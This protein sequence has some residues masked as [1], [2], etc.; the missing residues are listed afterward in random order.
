M[1]VFFLTT[2]L[3]WPPHQGGRVRTLSQLRLLS[4][5]PEV[6]SICIFSLTEVA[7]AESDCA[8][9]A[10]AIAAGNPKPPAIQVLPP[11]FHPIHIKRDPKMLLKVL[12]R[13]LRHGEPYLLGKWHSREV[14]AALES[15]LSSATYDV[16]YIDHL[17]M[18][19]YLP[20]VRAQC[21]RARFVLEEH[22]V[23]SD[24]FAQLT[25]RL[26]LPL[27]PV[28]FLEHRTAAR[29]EAERLLAKRARGPNPWR[30]P[31]ATHLIAPGVAVIQ[32]P[33]GRAL[34][35]ALSGG[36]YPPRGPHNSLF[37]VSFPWMLLY[38]VFGVMSVFID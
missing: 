30:A 24:M 4:A 6:E 25:T 16:I 5:Q 31:W 8:A 32:Y 21:P 38:A 14:A 26:P 22:N 11:V 34:L 15:A 10:S 9:L 29:A 3:P 20:L 23:E 1:R 19:A 17:G 35:L 28:S 27:K 18:G 12:G 13:R 7:V 2:E 36:H 33:L 37:V